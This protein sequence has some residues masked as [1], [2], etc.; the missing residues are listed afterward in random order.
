MDLKS[1]VN[2]SPPPPPGTIGLPLASRPTPLPVQ[3][4]TVAAASQTMHVLRCTNPIAD[5][6]QSS[7]CGKYLPEALEF[8]DT[9]IFP[10][11][12][13]CAAADRTMLTLN[14]GRGPR[15]SQTALVAGSFT[16]TC[17]RAERLSPNSTIPECCCSTFTPVL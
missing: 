3:A 13:F 6:S 9:P 11:S 15:H 16:W 7:Y 12:V 4:A 5:N 8:S 10:A 14:H 2:G 1:G 17:G